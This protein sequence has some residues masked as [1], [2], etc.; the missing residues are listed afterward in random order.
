MRSLPFPEN[1]TL[2]SGCLTNKKMSA[3]HGLNAVLIVESA[4][5]GEM[6]PVDFL[7]AAPPASLAVFRLVLHRNRYDLLVKSGREPRIAARRPVFDFLNL[8]LALFKE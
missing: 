4:A 3:A 7:N 8:L 2:L 5:I 1:T 6:L